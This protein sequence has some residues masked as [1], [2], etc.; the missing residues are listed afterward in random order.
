MTQ[1]TVVISLDLELSWG[2][3]DLSFDDDL[4]KMARWTH[5]MGVPTLLRHLTRNGLSAS[6]AVVGA[7]MRSSLPD[8]SKL[9]EVR[10]RHFS[11]P[12][13]SHVPES[14]EESTH[15]EWFGAGLVEM[16]KR[17]KPEQEIGF[18]SFS[19]V[20]FGVAGMTRERAIAE[21]QY[22]AQTARELGIPTTCFVFP[23]NMVAY[24][25]ELRDAGFTCFRDVDELQ[26]RFRNKTLTSIGMVAA[27]F[28]GLTPLM[29]EP[30]FKEGI[31]S[32]PGSLLIRCAA[33]WRKYIPDSSRLRRLRKG[34]ERV[35]Q[36]G[37]VFHVWFHPENLYA[38]WPRL[39]N[40]VAR[41]L[42]DLGVS[43]H[44]GDVR[45]LTMGQL[46][47]EFQINLAQSRDPNLAYALA[48][49]VD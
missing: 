35:R 14:G 3:F 43:V 49:Y 41:F 12:W 30:S 27:D 26:I 18:H 29:V 9:P 34:L 33:G 36:T 32:I 21:Y 22:C 25:A 47:R 48:G 28:V 7:M 40:V 45:C 42:E 20:P 4:L 37:G 5:D 2:S 15:P 6:W 10:F 13:F 24:I 38:E 39:E 8:V 16:I 23:R 19:H 11:K 44:N 46:A 17:A 31:V 1:P